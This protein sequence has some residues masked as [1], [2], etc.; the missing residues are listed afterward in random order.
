MPLA[1]AWPCVAIVLAHVPDIHRV[2]LMRLP[3]SHPDHCCNDASV[4]GVSPAE[5][6]PRGSQGLSAVSVCAVRGSRRQAPFLDLMLLR[7]RASPT[8]S[9]YGLG[10]FQK[11]RAISGNKDAEML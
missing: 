11:T 4:R 8:L 10:Q 1:N 7:C 6:V 5:R 3:W 9:E 2:S